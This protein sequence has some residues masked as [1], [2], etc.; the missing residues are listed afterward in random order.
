MN[1]YERKQTTRVRFPSHTLLIFLLYRANLIS[2]IFVAG[3][4]NVGSNPSS[5]TDERGRTHDR[6]VTKSQRSLIMAA[7]A[8]LL[9]RCV[10]QLVRESI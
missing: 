4:E 7:T 1:P 5:R 3:V 6:S 10:S 8:Y 9:N 2:S